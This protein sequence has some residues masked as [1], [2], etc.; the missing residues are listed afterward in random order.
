MA[1]PL[2]ARATACDGRKPGELCK[3]NGQDY[4]SD[5]TLTNSFGIDVA[6]HVGSN[7]A[8]RFL[9]LDFQEA[10][11]PNSAGEITASS[12]FHVID[13]DITKKTSEPFG[14]F[15]YDDI[16]VP[17]GLSGKSFL[18][19][20]V[21]VESSEERRR[22]K[23]NSLFSPSK[24]TGAFSTLFLFPTHADCRSLFCWS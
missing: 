20:S 16:K 14:A 18:N 7:S 6:G 3:L 24:L 22:A 23:I 8:M 11:Q 15:H 10:N 1:S 17:C 2:Q 9:S 12:N 21:D 19:V 13:Y 5:T 4:N